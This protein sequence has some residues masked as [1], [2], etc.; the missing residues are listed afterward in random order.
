VVEQ[1]VHGDGTEEPALVVDD[2]CGDEVVRREVGRDL[3]DAG[4]RAQ[5]VQG[6]VQG[7]LPVGV[8]SGWR[9]T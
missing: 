2:G 5:R 7:S 8:S 6:L 1:V 9:Q 3:V 4:V